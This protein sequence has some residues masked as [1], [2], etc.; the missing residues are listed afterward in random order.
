MYGG[1]LPPGACALVPLPEAVRGGAQ[2]K[3]NPWGAHA[4][5]V[6]PTMRVPQDVRWHRDLAYNATWALLAEVARWNADA[7]ADASAVPQGEGGASRANVGKQRIERVLMTGLG[8]GAGG[9]SAER[10]ARQMVL[11]VKHFGEDLPERVR[12]ETVARRME[13]VE[14]SRSCISRVTRFKGV[15]RLYIVFR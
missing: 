10:C 12:W 11:A 9:V 15:T 3:G 13:E 6:L 2:G 8:T 4:L 5:A 14:G 1:F 7:G